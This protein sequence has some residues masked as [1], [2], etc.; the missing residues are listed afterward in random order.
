MSNGDPGAQQDGADANEER[1][2]TFS[3]AFAEAARKSGLG[4]LKPGENPSGTALLGAIGGVRGII[5]SVVPGIGFLVI[6]LSTGGLTKQGGNL[7]LSVIIPVVLALVFVVARAGAK[8]SMTSAIAGA[9]GLAFTAILTLLTNKASTNFVPGIVINVVF[10]VA[11]LVSLAVRWPLIGMVVGALF[12]DLTG[13]RQDRAKRRV[14]TI[15]TWLWVGLFVIRLALEVPLY[16]AG[17]VPALGIVRLITSVPL[18]AAFLWVTWLLVR[19]AYAGRAPDS[20]ADDD[21]ADDV[22]D[23]V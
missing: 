22:S 6:Y 19:G 16:I 1:P 17:N 20:D 3:E 23:E 13:W 9:V 15:A 10:L 5:E 18:Y 4:Q 11:L 14:L 12:G 2:Q 21:E 7:A 8:S